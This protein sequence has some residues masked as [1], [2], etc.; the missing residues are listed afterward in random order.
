[1]R[2]VA[3]AAI[4]LLIASA[5]AQVLE[6]SLLWRVTQPGKRDTSYL[7]GTIHSRD[8]R[9][10][11]FQ[12]SVL[13]FFDRCQM[14]AGELDMEESRKISPEITEA[15]FLPNGSSLDRLYS[16]RDY[17]EVAT[18]LKMR[19]GPLAPMSLK[20]RP[21][22]TLA[23]I[24]EMQLGTDSSLVLD[25][26]LQDRAL[27]RGMK[28]IGLETVHEQLD[29]IQRIP[30]RDQSKLL[31]RVLR[32]DSMGYKADRAIDA[33]SEHDLEAL[34]AIIGRDGLPEHADKALLMERNKTMAERLQRHIRAGKRVFAA[35]GAAH[36]AGERGMIERLRS[37]GYSVSPVG[38]TSNAPY[39][40]P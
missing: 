4:Y 29:A 38:V 25:A 22:Y 5:G 11:R 10:F 27:R 28:V 24:T 32:D 7:F 14:L 23:M 20:V 39:I 6:R 19:L 30:L 40:D 15:M 31:L 3:I 37:M 9:A 18:L 2:I 36:L 33:Y 34:M 1:M 21:Y 35:V 13:Y 8:A 12:D 16:K 17:R 26:W